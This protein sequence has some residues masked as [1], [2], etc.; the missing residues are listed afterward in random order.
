MYTDTSI[1]CVYIDNNALI[2]RLDCRTTD[3]HLWTDAFY[4]DLTS[5]QSILSSDDSRAPA[6]DLNPRL[7]A[8][9]ASMSAIGQYFCA[10][11]DSVAVP[12][13]WA[14]VRG[15]NFIVDESTDVDG[16][17]YNSNFTD[18]TNGF[19]SNQQVNS[20]ASSSSSNT[21]SSHRTGSSGGRLNSTGGG[22]SSWS[23]R[24]D[25][26]AHNVRRRQW[27]RVMVPEQHLQ[28]ALDACDKYLARNPRGH[29]F[30]SGSLYFEVGKCCGRAYKQLKAMLFDDN[31]LMFNGN[32]KE[33]VFAL[34]PMTQ[35]SQS[36]SRNKEFM[37]HP[38]LFRLEDTSDPFAPRLLRVATSDP[39]ARIRWME[40]IRN[41][42]ALIDKSG[43]DM[44]GGPP[45]DPSVPIYSSSLVSYFNVAFLYYVLCVRSYPHMV[46]LL[47]RL[48]SLDQSSYT[49]V[50]SRPSNLS[51]R[52]SSASM[53]ESGASSGR[54][55]VG[56]VSGG[57]K[58]PLREPLID[59]DS[60]VGSSGPGANPASAGGEGVKTSSYTVPAL[61]PPS[62][63]PSASHGVS[64]PGKIAMTNMTTT[65]TA[66]ANGVA[67]TLSS[68]S[69]NTGATAITKAPAASSTASLDA[70][71]TP[72]STTSPMIDI[73][74]L[75]VGSLC[76]KRI[77]GE[78]LC[79]SI[80]ARS[81]Y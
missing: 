73:D 46:L 66:A 1:P 60:G 42:V 11:M 68:P 44:V 9:D 47:R 50:N 24:F 70:T 40:I 67:A 45:E 39:L 15:F 77:M 37:R 53:R 34:S 38:F 16:W 31:L 81:L 19:A 80:A 69:P 18:D 41:H 7:S 62:S 63:V 21:S 49:T 43:R 12:D 72:T 71:A 14:V 17:Q 78:F 75:N 36:D 64:T 25:T 10:N 56:N 52:G 6:V 28:K 30:S 26:K 29:I 61:A 65:T 79:L 35:L 3:P 57:N 58:S 48:Y 51:S 2:I 5:V 27:C 23:N 20:V 74:V 33:G 22:K 59:V 54:A 32:R 8:R 55:S 13:G 76:R 4:A